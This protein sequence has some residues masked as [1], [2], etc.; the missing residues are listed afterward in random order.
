MPVNTNIINSS[1]GKE[2]K[3]GITATIISIDG[4]E[5]ITD[6]SNEL[7]TIDAGVYGENIRY[8]IYNA[9]VKV[10]NFAMP[11]VGTQD[12][13]DAI[14]TKNPKQLYIIIGDNS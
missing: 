6:I 8:A 4:Y 10:Y 12:E 3:E 7:N 5:D 14:E 2:I 1:Y 9:L 11:W 13:Y